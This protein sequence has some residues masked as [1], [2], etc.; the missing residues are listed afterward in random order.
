[1][2]LHLARSVQKTLE[3]VTL[4]HRMPADALL[5]KPVLVSWLALRLSEGALLAELAIPFPLGL[6]GI[7]NL[8]IHEKMIS[9]LSLVSE[10]AIGKAVACGACQVSVP[11]NT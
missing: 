9:G 4:E 10:L 2:L 6:V 1:M 7:N 11:I 3:A 8:V 5:A